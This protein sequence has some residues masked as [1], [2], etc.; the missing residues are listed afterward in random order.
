ME[1]LGLKMEDVPGNWSDML[2]FIIRL[3][4]RV[5]PE[6][7]INLFY[8]NQSFEDA[9]R[10][11]FKQLL[12][13][14]QE[15]ASHADPVIG[16]DT[17][18]LREL[19]NKLE[20]IDFTRFGCKHD[21]GNNW[22]AIREPEGDLYENDDSLSLFETDTGC[23]FGSFY[24]NFSPI[25]LSMDGMTPSYMV[26]NMSVAFIN[27]HSKHPNEAMLFME[28]LA[29]CISTGTLYCVDPSLNEPIRN[30]R[31]GETML[32]YRESLEKLKAACESA[33]GAEKQ[34]LEAQIRDLEELI[35]EYSR[36]RWDISQANIDWFRANDKNIVLQSVKRIFSDNAG[37]FGE[38]IDQYLAGTIDA[39]AMLK[40]IDKKLS[41]THT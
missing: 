33:E 34:G 11:L 25:L 15:Y 8:A 26:M 38:L 28:H 39:D 1:R 7:K 21:V 14:Y 16:F 22:S 32:E 37:D 2:D 12:R 40:G 27:P 23:S 6:D 18:L 17:K 4:E 3:A 31:Y 35:A 13:D 9:K 29:D 10:M 24:S 41:A 36:A 30:S 20:A 19:L 5:K